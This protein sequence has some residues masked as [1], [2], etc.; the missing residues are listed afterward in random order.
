MFDWLKPS[1]K[2]KHWWREQHD[3]TYKIVVSESAKPGK[4]VAVIAFTDDMPVQ[5][6][7]AALA[8]IVKGLDHG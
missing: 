1:P 4:M 5:A 8:R 6:Q 3:G 7:Q 2:F